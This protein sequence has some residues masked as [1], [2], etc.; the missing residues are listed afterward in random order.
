MGR[1]VALDPVGGP[2]HPNTAGGA[3]SFFSPPAPTMLP[4]SQQLLRHFPRPSHSLS[5]PRSSRPASENGTQGVP[6]GMAGKVLSEESSSDFS[7]LSVQHS[8]AEARPFSGTGCRYS[9]LLSFALSDN[10]T[11]TAGGGAAAGSSR[12]AG[13][14]GGGRTGGG[15]VPGQRCRHRYR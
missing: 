8:A 11:E 9:Q 2:R 3:G 10:P 12:T 7:A 4:V 15:E 13:S 1:A 6:Q 5:R 14:G